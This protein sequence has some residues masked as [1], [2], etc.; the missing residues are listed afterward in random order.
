MLTPDSITVEAGIEA[1]HYTSYEEFARR[2]S[3]VWAA[4]V[5][6]FKPVAVLQQGLRYVNH[7]ERELSPAG[8]SKLI[9]PELLGSIS[10]TLSGGLVQAMCDLRFQREDGMLAFKH[11]LVPAGPQNKLGYLL[12]FDCFSQKRSEDASVE[13]LVGRFDRDHDA[14]YAFFRWC[15]TE[16]ALK[17]FRDAG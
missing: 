9:N 2:F 4:L 11:G 14:I 15:V 3:G 7:I 13:A 16:Q 8:W 10:T 17:E 5:E 1:G 12:D 6:H